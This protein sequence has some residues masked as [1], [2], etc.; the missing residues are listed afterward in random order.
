MTV[1]A[2]LY[3]VGVDAQAI[4]NG[5]GVGMLPRPWFQVERVAVYKGGA[6]R[7]HLG[8]EKANRCGFAGVV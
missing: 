1:I 3:R 7:T 5:P 4:W 2:D 8:P 6:A